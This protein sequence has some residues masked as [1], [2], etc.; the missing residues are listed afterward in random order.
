M[1][2]NIFYRSLKYESWLAPKGFM[3]N[4]SFAH[5]PMIYMVCKGRIYP[6]KGK[7]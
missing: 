7:L 1:K 4:V 3:Y 2:E 6:D 5:Y